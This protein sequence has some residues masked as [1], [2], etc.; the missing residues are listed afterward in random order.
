M[1]VSRGELLSSANGLRLTAG[2]LELGAVVY[3]VLGGVGG[4]L[5]ALQTDSDGFSESH[6]FVAAGIGTAVV[7]VATA[8]V[9]WAFARALALFAM[10]VDFRTNNTAETLVE[11]A[12]AAESATGHA[13]RTVSIQAADL[14]V[15]MVVPNERGEPDR[16]T[17][18]ARG[19]R[20]VRVTLNS[21]VTLLF[22]PK[23]SVIRF[24]E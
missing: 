8:M 22:D 24:L 16:I 14:Q 2:W 17:H 12:V 4:I 7:A 6:P 19:G 3:G 11:A 5:L 23:D 1:A 20:G 13:V 10:D 15:G 18:A 21:G 9:A